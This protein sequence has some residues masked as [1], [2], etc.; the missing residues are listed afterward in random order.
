MYNHD[1]AGGDIPPSPPRT[2]R[3]IGA[4][5]SMGLV[6]F[7]ILALA[8]LAGAGVAVATYARLAS[9]LPAPTELEQIELPQQSVVYDRTGTV[10]LARFGDFN[11]QVVTFDE[12]PPVLIDATTAV[13]D[14][15]FWENAG[16]DPVGIISAGLDA[17]RGNARGGSTITQQL[18]R[19]RLL[20]TNGEAQTQVTASRKLREIIQ[21]IRVTQAYSGVEGKQKIITA[22]LNQNYYGNDAYGVAAAAQA[23]FGIGLK[24]L[25]L[26]QAAILAAIPQAPS[27]YDLVQ[28]AV[29]QCIDPTQPEDT[30]E[31]QL[32]VPADA[33]VV[34]RRNHV[35]DLMEQNGTPLTD[36]QYTAAD[37]EAARNEPVILAPQ[38]SSQWKDPQFVYQVRR[39]L[40]TQLCG[41]GAETC[42][43]LERGGLRITSTLDLD[44]QAIAEKWVKAAAV[45][46]NAK[47]PRAAARALGISY[48]PWMAKISRGNLH[49]GA[50]IAMDYQTGELVAYV[51]SADPTATKATKKFQPRFDVL[52][53][54]WR[55]PGSAFK[56][57][58]YVT[59]INDRIL[60]AASMFMDVVTDF[61][62]GY[63]PTDADSLERGPVRLRNA[64]Q[65]S[66][67]IPA[68]KATAVIGNDNIQSTAE[69]M[70]IQFQNGQVSAGASFALGV[71]VVHPLDLVGAYGV[72]ADG[73]QKVQQTTIITVTDP[74]GAVI[75]SEQD[76]PAPNPVL[77]PGSAAIVTD[78]L[79]GNT[80]PQVNPYW[81]KFEITDGNKRRPAAL[82]TGTNNE[83]RDL[84][85]YGYIA[86]PTSRGRDKGEYALAVGVWN[87][88]SDNSMVGKDVVLTSLDV[89][90]YVWQGFLTEATKGWAIR[91]FKLP[92]SL[93]RATVDPWSGL[94]TSSRPSVDEL[95]LA[96]TKPASAGAPGSVCGVAVL[97]VAGFENQHAAWMAA[98]QGWIKRADKGAGVRGGPKR[99]PTAYFYNGHPPIAGYT[100]YGK[101]WGAIAGG[102]GCASPS[103]SPSASFDPC[104]PGASLDPSASPVVCPSPSEL[105]SESVAP[106]ATPTAVPTATPT[107]A[108]TKPPPTP[109]PAPTPTKPPPT[110][111]PA[112][113][114]TKPPPPSPTPAASSAAGSG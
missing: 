58:V 27:S 44:L 12:I 66:L 81:G 70:G 31:T 109:T 7:A 32:V 59:G 38:R 52:G 106:T 80:N 93:E 108:P 20:T 2:R 88:N 26:A 104:A 23:Y 39:E 51:G 101:S 5:A 36:G 68:V 18:V 79:A 73:G 76:L 87:G 17:L 37:Y 16:F 3:G 21:S 102:G 55:Q 86:A 6:L 43:V 13:E 22:Y 29:E 65:F 4:A 28:N 33:P 83:A 24:E 61:G 9:D 57:I 54:G 90:T 92:A 49:N 8:G 112:P 64:L 41:E 74:S 96:G 42:P 1:P 105:P 114:P 78:I 40:T 48:Q 75:L 71:E 89:P 47:N 69:A 103:P 82:K 25:T 56:P 45:V 14:R 34:Q 94:A 100:P 77:D 60:T 19:Q 107:P 113:T 97:S 111:T 30:C 110:P 46:P 99:T 50:L 63:T 53:D 62:G 95:F 11:R 15:T 85:A 98:D 35:L 91:D 67:N 72:I 10:E 84:S